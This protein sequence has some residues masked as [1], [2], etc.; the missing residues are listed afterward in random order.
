MN[1]SIRIF[2]A[3]VLALT[4]HNAW[5]GDAKVEKSNASPSE[6]KGG[7]MMDKEHMQQMHEHM[8][9]MHKGKAM[10]DETC[11]MKSDGK[12]AAKDMKSA[13]KTIPDKPKAAANADEHAQ[14]H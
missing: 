5:A 10:G 2:A 11:A 12:C 9:D 8:N 6:M 1:I 14:H 13:N 4:L 7:G 3:T